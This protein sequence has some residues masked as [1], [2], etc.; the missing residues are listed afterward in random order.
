MKRFFS[1]AHALVRLLDAPRPARGSPR[2]RASSA[3]ASSSLEAPRAATGLRLS[4]SR[5]VRGPS[6]AAPPAPPATGA[7]D[8]SSRAMLARRCFSSSFALFGLAPPWAR[9]ASSVRSLLDCALHALPRSR[10]SPRRP[11]T[12][13]AWRRCARA[14]AAPPS[15]DTT[16]RAEQRDRR[17]GHRAAPGRRGLELLGEEHLLLAP[18]GARA[19]DLL[20]V[21]L[22]RS[23]LAS[24]IQVLRRHGTRRA[25]AL[26]GGFRLGLRLFGLHDRVL[27]RLVRFRS[28]SDTAQ[29]DLVSS[30]RLHMTD[31]PPLSAMGATAGRLLETRN[32]DGVRPQRWYGN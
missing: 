19:A 25:A 7:R 28:M 18:Q 15:A 12:P 27:D 16:W 20:E 26:G 9:W 31:D 14:R 23:P 24:G 1:R 29:S 3:S 2:A 22:E 30:I 17:R 5:Q 13:R 21:R 11:P 32:G 10:R 4:S 6:G 8:L